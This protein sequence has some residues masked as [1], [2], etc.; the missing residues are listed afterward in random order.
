MFAYIWGTFDEND[1]FMDAN[2]GLLRASSRNLRRF[3][4]RKSIPFP[5]RSS[6]MNVIPPEVPM[7]GMAGGEKANVWADGIF[8]NS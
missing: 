5:A 4:A 3:S 6:S 7:P 8:D 1:V 2:S